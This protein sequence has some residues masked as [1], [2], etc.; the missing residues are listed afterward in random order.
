MLTVYWKVLL[1]RIN[2]P[3]SFRFVSA[4]S[5]QLKLILG[6]VTGVHVI[7]KQ[8]IFYRYGSLLAELLMYPA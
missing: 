3:F 8:K 1:R 6:I 7:S 5:N 4:Q 2:I